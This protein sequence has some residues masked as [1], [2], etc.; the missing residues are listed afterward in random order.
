[1]S[2][3]DLCAAISRDRQKGASVA[4]LAR[5]YR[6]PESE[7]RRLLK[8]ARAR[9]ASFYSTVAV[10]VGSSDTGGPAPSISSHKARGPGS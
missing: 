8:V 3:D 6:E 1:M 10:G 4:E 7:I 9:Y 2:A 5:L